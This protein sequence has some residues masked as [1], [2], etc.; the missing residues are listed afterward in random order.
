MCQPPQSP[1]FNVLD[2]NFYSIQVLLV[3]LIAAL[4]EPFASLPC[5]T[6]EKTLQTWK[7]VMHV[8][9]DINGDKELKISCLKATEGDV[10]AL[11]MMSLRLEE[12]DRMYE[13]SSLVNVM[14][15]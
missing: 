15:V 14:E 4:E 13:L 12:N 6:L 7:R 3:E 11:E 10:I 9:I 8:A 1:D 5:E 2:L